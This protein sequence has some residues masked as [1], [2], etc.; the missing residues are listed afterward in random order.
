[1]MPSLMSAEAPRTAAPSVFSVPK[2]DGEANALE[3]LVQRSNPVREISPNSISGGQS[4][5]E[6]VGP[7]QQREFS[8]ELVAV[9]QVVLSADKLQGAASFA[10]N[11]QRVSQ[12]LAKAGELSADQLIAE[13][14]KL[15]MTDPNNSVETHNELYEGLS[16]LRQAAIDE[17]LAKSERAEEMKKEADHY[18][19]TFG[20]FGD[21]LGLVATVAAI[22]GAI[23][24]S[25]ATLLLLGIAG[26]VCGAVSAGINLSATQQSLEA[27]TVDVMASRMRQFAE[28]NQAGVEEEAKVI[29]L[30]LESKNKAVQAVMKMINANHGTQL[31]L[32]SGSR[33]F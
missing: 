21:F 8:L 26:S 1:M 28:L 18:A 6:G 20:A 2:R 25:G 23:F 9:P 24:T 22:G 19:S 16:R 31:K 30:I 3:S 11:M 5:K 15:E 29:E 4:K 10:R 17:A 14:L 33:S 12:G 13:Y 27:Q 7:S 32:I